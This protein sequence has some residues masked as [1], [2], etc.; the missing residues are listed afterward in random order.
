MFFSVSVSSADECHSLAFQPK[1]IVVL[2]N[3]SCTS[4]FGDHRVLNKQLGVVW[5]YFDTLLETDKEYNITVHTNESCGTNSLHSEFK[6]YVCGEK[7]KCEY[8]ITESSCA[9]VSI[10]LSSNFYRWKVL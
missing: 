6:Y 5:L 8:D 9:N 3:D 7:K 1:H 2:K 4:S 10:D